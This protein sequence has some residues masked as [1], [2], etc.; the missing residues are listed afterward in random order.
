MPGGMRTPEGSSEPEPEPAV[1]VPA[2]PAVASTTPPAIVV[3]TSDDGT[4]EQFTRRIVPFMPPVVQQRAGGESSTVSHF[5]A[6]SD[7]AP[8]NTVEIVGLRYA[9]EDLSTHDALKTALEKADPAELW[10]PDATAGGE[11]GDG[12]SVLSAGIGA[13]QAS[14]SSRQPPVAVHVEYTAGQG[15]GASTVRET[16]YLLPTLTGLQMKSA[17]IAALG[18]GGGFQDYFLRCDGD[19]FGSRTAIST[20]PGFQEGCVLS[21][22][23]V[24]GRPKAVGHT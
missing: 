2:A 14:L 21:M 15:E 13:A 24:A 23:D 10:G 20:H 8:E 6:R 5:V 17:V 18:L 1:A 12:H 22:E 4:W 19:V 11:T 7:A 16:V 3:S 9:L